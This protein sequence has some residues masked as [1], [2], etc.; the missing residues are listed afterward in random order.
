MFKR[1]IVAACISLTNQASSLQ[2]AK[3]KGCV[4][5]IAVN[6]TPSHSYGVLLTNHH[7]LETRH[8]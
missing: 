6:G 2:K 3:G 7:K 4:G 1:L 8:A 5:P